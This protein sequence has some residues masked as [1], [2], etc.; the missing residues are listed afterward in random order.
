[1]KFKKKIVQY[2]DCLLPDAEFTEDITEKVVCR[3]VS[4]DASHMKHRLT[5][6]HGDKIPGRA[7]VQ[8]RV[9]C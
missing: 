1:M 3:D 8:S 4:G 2:R 7:V 5:N 9:C 6:V